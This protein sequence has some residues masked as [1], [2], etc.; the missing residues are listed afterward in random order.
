[1][2]N[3][4]ASLQVRGC[5]L[6]F[7]SREILDAITL[8]ASAMMFKGINRQ[9][10]KGDGVEGVMTSSYQVGNIGSLCG[11]IFNLTANFEGFANDVSLDFIL[12]QPV[13]ESEL[14]NMVWVAEMSDEMSECPTVH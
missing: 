9:K 5:G 10:I 6:V 3:R 14:R 7:S 11:Y 4:I 2:L 12:T 8:T 1:M 13:T